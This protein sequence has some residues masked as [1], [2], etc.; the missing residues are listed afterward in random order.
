M[1]KAGKLTRHGEGLAVRGRYRAN[2]PQMFSDARQRR[3]QR[4]RL[5]A[6]QKVRDRLFVN[7]QPIGD[8]QKIEF[9]LLRLAGDFFGVIQIN[10]GIGLRRRMAPGRHVSRCA[11]QNGTQPKLSCGHDALSF[12]VVAMPDDGGQNRRALAG[13]R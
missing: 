7:K 13:C 12:L 9:A 11:M 10:T 8:K 6:I 3:E 2:Q 4:Q 1:I 5:K